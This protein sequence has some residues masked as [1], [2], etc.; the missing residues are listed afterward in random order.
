MYAL[1]SLYLAGAP[2]GLSR[3]Y[4]DCLTVGAAKRFFGAT[5]WK[6]LIIGAGICR[7]CC[8]LLQTIVAS[9]VYASFQGRAG[10]L[11]SPTET[12]SP[13]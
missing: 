3:R 8:G 5:E 12:I 7:P 9:I 10:M 6:A 1:F 2:G 11:V 13:I 4:F